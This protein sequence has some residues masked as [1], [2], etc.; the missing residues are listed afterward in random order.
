MKSEKGITL[1]SLIIYIILLILVVSMLSMISDLFFT[2]TQYI[3]DNSK[4]IAE[5]N[6]FN[7]YFI[8]DVKNNSNTYSIN[9]QEIVFED[10]TVYTY[11]KSPDKGIYRNK[12]KICDNIEYCYFT[13]EEKT[14]NDFTK[15]IIN[16]HIIIKGS[17]IFETTNDYVLKYW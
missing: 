1:L 16:V 2:N 15:Q 13:K 4:Y 9:E 14:V 5:F 6:K 7:M 10:G 17:R 11:K 12:V 3:K 8:E